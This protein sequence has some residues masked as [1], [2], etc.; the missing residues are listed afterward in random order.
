MTKIA[1]T[2]FAVPSSQKESGAHEG[3]FSMVREIFNDLL[4]D[5]VF[6]LSKLKNYIFQQKMDLKI[7]GKFYVYIILFL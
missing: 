2:R 1:E 6:S 3:F 5:D 4:S 7:Q